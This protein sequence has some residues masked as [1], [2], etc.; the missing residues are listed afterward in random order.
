[1]LIYLLEMTYFDATSLQ[2]VTL[3]YS[4]GQQGYCT[5][6]GDS[7]PNTFYEPRLKVP[8]NYQ[9]SVFQDGL[10]GGS[11]D[12]GFGV[13]ELLNH[14]GFFD[15]FMTQNWDGHTVRLLYGDDG[16]GGNTNGSYN[17]FN[18]LLTGVM[19]QPE[20]TWNMMNLK[21]RDYT[22]LFDK[23][24]SQFTYLGNNVAGKGVEG[25]P[26]DLMGKSKP[27]CFGRCYN[28]TPAWV[29]QAYLIYQFHNGPAQAVDMVYSNG[30]PLALDYG[31]NGTVETA[32]ATYVGAY[33]FSLTGVNKTSTYV[34]GLPLVIT[35]TV[36]ASGSTTTYVGNLVVLSSTYTGGNTVVTLGDPAGLLYY[37]FAFTSGCAITRIAYGGGDCPALAGTTGLYAAVPQPGMYCTCLALGIFMTSG[38]S[39]STAITADVRGDATG[40]VYVNTIADIVQRIA[41]SYAQRPRKNYLP[42][43]EAFSSGSWTNSGFTLALNPAGVAP[44]VAG[45][46]L[47]QLSGAANSNFS[48]TLALG[49]GMYCLSWHVKGT[50]NVVLEISDPSNE[51]NNCQATFNLT[52][53]LYSNVQANG[54]A[55]GPQYQATGFITEAGVIGVPNGFWRIWL[56]GQPNSSFTNLKVKIISADSTAFVIGG[57]MVE[58]YASPAIYTGPTTGTPVGTDTVGAYY[59][60]G[61]DPIL[62][63]GINAASFAAFKTAA[64]YEVGYYLGPGDTTTIGDFNNLLLE[65]AG[66]WSAF[67]RSGNLMAGQFNK[68]SQTA[69]PVQTFNP[70]Y[71]LSDSF[72][73]S[74]P[75]QTKDGTPAFRIVLDCACN[76]TPQAQATLASALWTNNPNRVAWVAQQWRQARAEDITALFQH[77]LACELDF[78]TYLTQQSDA[79]TE[80][81]RLLAIYENRLDK[82]TFTTKMDFAIGIT[83]GSVINI[84]V[85]RFGLTNGKNFVVISMTEAHETGHVTIGVMG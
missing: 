40:G 42:W 27:M 66:G 81:A 63:P 71:I 43:S 68:A 10:K 22:E 32:A 49:T 51:A 19:C 11:A 47:A 24:L 31:V 56:A 74:A 8:L 82:F 57:A 30:S 3:R 67:D 26:T 69:T 46:G 28:I 37:N 44:P 18:V 38:G 64:P 45:M 55:V 25:Q 33:S 12:G 72:D 65:S 36:T 52:T 76:F 14:D 80:C 54:L 9:C 77:P 5:L 50:G 35:Y 85:P 75:F 17:N 53:G 62:G 84:A 7:V 15:Q 59:A 73:R 20:F 39:A 6:P 58:A 2:P 1:M 78:T 79:I 61:Y 60:L 23:A 48:Y 41:T 21:V 4:S 34:A 16:A 29:S 70:W 13:A 83:V